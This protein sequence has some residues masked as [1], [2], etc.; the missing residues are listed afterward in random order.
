MLTLPG[1]KED[2]DQSEVAQYYPG[3]DQWEY[4]IAIHFGEK[5]DFVALNT[6]VED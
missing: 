3:D 4:F 1:N 5:T 2:G 6:K